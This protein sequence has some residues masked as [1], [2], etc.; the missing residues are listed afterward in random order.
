MRSPSITLPAGGA[1]PSAVP[2]RISVG[3]VIAPTVVGKRC[4]VS[5]SWTAVR[6]GTLPWWTS[7]SER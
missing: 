3:T 4:T 5:A 2:Y 7:G 6:A 1:S